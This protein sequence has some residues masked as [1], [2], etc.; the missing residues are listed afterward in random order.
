MDSAAKRFVTGMTS[1]RPGESRRDLMKTAAD[2][3]AMRVRGVYSGLVLD[4]P[5]RPRARYGWGA[6][7]HPGLEALIR[8]G[9]DRYRVVL[10]GFLAHRADFASITLDSPAA[11]GDPQWSNTFIPGLDGVALYSFVA[12]ERPVTYMEVGSGNSTKFVRR[13]IRDHSPS[14]TIV[15]IDPHPRAE[16]DALC[17]EVVRL[18]V[19]DADLTVFDRLR[20]G[21]VLFVDNSHRAFQNSDATVMLTE[22]IPSL[23]AGVLVGIHDIFLPEDYPPQWA[24]R[25]YSEQYLLAAWLLG[26]GGGCEVVLPAHYIRS[27]PELDTLCDPIWAA[28]ALATVQR[29]GG[30]FWLRTG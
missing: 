22:V 17:D 4:Y 6:P 15:S 12:D 16:V 3:L 26:G 9:V 10:E 1:P 25:Y 24:D 2:R 23:P 27:I 18:P 21:D 30:A 8:P 5:V 19:E 14:T 28:P 11:P 13:A 29:H 7:L 20:A